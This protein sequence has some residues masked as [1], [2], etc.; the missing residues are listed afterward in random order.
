MRIDIVR[1]QGKLIII[2][3]LAVLSGCSPVPST[4][5]VAQ[6]YESSGIIT[7]PPYTRTIFSGTNF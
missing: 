5:S 6:A 4:Y 1:I 2:V 3:A 7:V